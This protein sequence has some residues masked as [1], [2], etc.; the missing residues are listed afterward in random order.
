M[1]IKFLAEKISGDIVFSEHPG[2]TLRKWRQIFEISQKDLALKLNLSPS[3]ISDY[4]S[5]RRKSPGIV[6]VRRVIE[7]LLEIDKERGYKIVSKYREIFDGFQM[8]VILDMMEYQMSINSS[9]FAEIID[10]MQLNDFERYVNGHTIVDSIKAILTLNSYDF[11]K[12]YGLTNERALVF[13]KVSTGRSPLVAVRVANLKP[14]VV[15]L[16]NLKANEVDEIA[17]KIAEVEKIPLIVTS[18]EL[19]EM[20]KAI[21]RNV[22]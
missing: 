19:D 11:Y 6:F 20:I 5:D 14:A 17:L 7:A 4:E 18:M 21:R 16:H 15:V 10:G 12:L 3:V 2:K 8:D 22:R 1:D 13:T 9:K